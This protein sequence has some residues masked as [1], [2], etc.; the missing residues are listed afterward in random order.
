MNIRYSASTIKL[1]KSCPFRFYCKITDQEKD[2]D[3]DMVYGDSGTVVH[4]TLEYYYKHMRDIP[5]NLAIQETKNIFNT[6]WEHKELDDPRINKEEYWLCVVNGVKRNLDPTHLEYEFNIKIN[7]EISFIGYADIMNVDKNWVGD[8]KTSTYKKNKIE[9]YREQLR[10]YAWATYEVFNINPDLW[11]D[12]NK[13]NKRVTF[14][15]NDEE[16]KNIRNEIIELHS[17]VKQRFK[18]QK[19]ER[20]P[21]RTNCYFCPY[22]GVCSTDLLR[23]NT[24]EKY[25]VIFHLKDNKL[26]VEAAIPDLF[27]RKIEKEIN[28]KIKNAFYIVQ[29]MAARGIKYDGIK[30]L[31]KRKDYGA[32]TFIGYSNT[33]Y[34]ILKQYAHGEGKKIRLVIKDYRDPEVLNQKIKV[35]DKLN[36]SFNLYEFQEKAVECLLNNRW[37]IVEI[38]TGGGK[39]AIAAEAIRRLGLRTLFLIDNKDL[40]LQTKKEYEDMLGVKCGIVGMGKREWNAAIV[41]ATIQTIAKHKRDFAF[42][43]AKFPLVIY[44]ETH[45]IAS[46]SFEEVSKY[47]I[48]SKYRF[49][50]SAT[51]KRDDGNDN[52][53]YAHTGTVVYRKNAY[54]LINEDVLVN[55]EVIFF[56]YG[57]TMEFSGDWQNEYQNCIRDSSV[58]NEMI[59]EIAEDFV[60]KGKNVMILT[61]MI[62]HGDWFKENIKNSDLIYGR[63]DDEIRVE[64]LD[65]FKAGSLKILIGNLKIFNKGINIKNLD[66][67]INAA[68]NAGD[69]VT[70]QTIGRVLRKNPGKTTAY[71]IDFMDPGNYC[72][73]HSL[74]RIKALKDQNYTVEIRD[75]KRGNI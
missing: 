69:V 57:A 66:V 16:I 3:V 9:G 12:F 53:I 11:V 63:T 10:Y 73:K 47:L 13:V 54:D 26:Q 68:G 37:G 31:Y 50:F 55:P 19:F 44:D 61:K 46:K 49:G 48:N 8:W 5:L 40:L 15:F 42:E 52:V 64:I 75:Y 17:E 34:N 27:H 20:R 30:R 21:S 59:K 7:D 22:K 71:Y 23:E 67:L 58:R 4:D 62:A 56:D 72:K 60:E 38:G 29:A 65:K 36:I 25:E 24:A 45:I 6:F 18:E 74:S 28:Y 2:K 32:E 33:I 39:T 35:P 51:A 41:L 70:V 1:L 14:K 43:L